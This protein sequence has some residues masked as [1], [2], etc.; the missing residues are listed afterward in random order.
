MVDRFAHGRALRRLVA[1]C[2]Q[3]CCPSVQVYLFTFIPM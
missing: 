2:P 1:T 3:K